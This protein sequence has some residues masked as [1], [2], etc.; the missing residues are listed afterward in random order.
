[1][2]LKIVTPFG[3]YQKVS[4]DA[5]RKRRLEPFTRVWILAGDLHTLRLICL[6]ELPPALEGLLFLLLVA[7]NLWVGTD[8]NG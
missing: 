6:V 7:R 8:R 5:K 4:V 1:M 3:K 2:G